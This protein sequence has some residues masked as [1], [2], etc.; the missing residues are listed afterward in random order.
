MT[1]PFSALIA[2][3]AISASLAAVTTPVSALEATGETRGIGS[4]SGGGGAGIAG[5]ES[6]VS[7]APISGGDLGSGRDGPAIANGPIS[8]G[9][10]GSGRINDFTGMSSGSGR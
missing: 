6:V 5:T 10:Q 7:R 3:L 4:V 8:S 2:A 9:D 1:K